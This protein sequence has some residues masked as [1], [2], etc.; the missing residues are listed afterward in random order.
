MK[1]KKKEKKKQMVTHPGLGSIE[2]HKANKI[3]IKKKKAMGK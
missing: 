2:V 1:E 3:K